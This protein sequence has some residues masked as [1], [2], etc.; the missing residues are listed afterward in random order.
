MASRSSGLT[1]ILDGPSSPSSFT[2]L[3]LLDVS[4]NNISSTGLAALA[5]VRTR[6][7]LAADNA[8]E[9]VVTSPARALATM[10][11]D[12]GE[13]RFLDLRGNRLSAQGIEELVI[14]AFHERSSLRRLDLSDCSLTVDAIEALQRGLLESP[15]CQLQ[16][17]TI[18]DR[19]GED[20]ASEAGDEHDGDSGSIAQT[21]VALKTA[22]GQQH[23]KLRVT[24]AGGDDDK[25]AA[26][27]VVSPLPASMPSFKE[28]APSSRPLTSAP[29]VTTR[30]PTPSSVSVD[31]I[32]PAI[33]TTLEANNSGD[34]RLRQADVE[35]IVSR[36]VE[37]MNRN[38]DE[39]IGQF[40]ARMETQQHEK[41]TSQLQFLLGK[42]EACERAIPRLE[43]RLDV[44]SDRVASGGAQLAKVQSELQAQMVTMRHEFNARLGTSSFSS[45]SP[46]MMPLP[47]P[48]PPSPLLTTVMQTQVDELVAIRIR[49]SEQKTHGELQKLRREA[50]AATAT[51]A[52]AAA[53]S[54]TFSSPLPSPMSTSSTADSQA[55]VLEAV[56]LHLSHFKRE[57]DD[58]QNGTLREF[59]ESIVCDGLRLEDRMARV[60]AQVATLEGVVQAEQ[61]ASLLAL[62][63]ISEA[64]SDATGALSSPSAKG[65][66]QQQSRQR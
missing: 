57:L 27:P 7:L 41:H 37:S 18:G 32:K 4:R 14:V 33:M 48:P 39:R 43:A 52:A 49:A 21:L 51:A 58:K 36:T 65:G 5:S 46:S 26:S 11:L 60:E 8:I 19:D 17:V 15:R 12:G 10:M 42:V 34:L 31:S 61:Q 25:R 55:A 38:F 1:S 64:F 24:I 9:G 44:L 54:S 40:L 29:P 6:T 30:P 62:E 23:L 13:L 50:A 2:G 35:L 22:V 59:T 16:E 66:A 53:A 47:P 63:A 45:P 3:E 20:N 28:A 56:S